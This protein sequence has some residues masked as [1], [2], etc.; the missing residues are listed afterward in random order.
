M[1]RLSLQFALLRDW[2]R[3][4]QETGN[5]Y[6]VWRAVEVCLDPDS[7]LPLPSWVATYLRAAGEKVRL[8]A[9]DDADFTPDPAVVAAILGFSSGKRG[10]KPKSGETLSGMPNLTE[11]QWKAARAETEFEP[12]GPWEFKLAADS[13]DI[14][15]FRKPAEH[16]AAAAGVSVSVVHRWRN[17]PVYRSA[18]LDLWCREEK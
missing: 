11:N 17:D 6:F 2:E 3:Q 8:A 5:A 12:G 1:R 15:A 7:P 14:A 16:V 18:V 4:Y 13:F 9:T 10:R